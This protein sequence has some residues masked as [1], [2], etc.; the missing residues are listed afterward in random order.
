MI[1]KQNY[2]FFRPS[3]YY[4]FLEYS[5]QNQGSFSMLS[6]TSVTYLLNYLFVYQDA[7]VVLASVQTEV[8]R[9]EMELDA[10]VREKV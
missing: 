8:Q 2:T 7:Q 6:Q 3:N 10:A 1:D 4:L 9:L 5:G